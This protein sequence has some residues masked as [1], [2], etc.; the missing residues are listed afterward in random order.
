MFGEQMR[1][2]QFLIVSVARFANKDTGNIRINEAIASTKLHQF[3]SWCRSIA[4]LYQS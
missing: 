4:A 1:T 3:T 2:F